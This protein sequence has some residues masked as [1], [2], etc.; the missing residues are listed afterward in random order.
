MGNDASLTHVHA[1]AFVALG[2]VDFSV[3]SVRLFYCHGTMGRCPFRREGISLETSTDVVQKA[4]AP[5]HRQELACQRVTGKK[6]KAAYD[7]FQVC[8]R[9]RSLLVSLDTFRFPPLSA[10]PI[11]VARVDSFEATDSEIQAL[12]GFMRASRREVFGRSRL[13]SAAACSF[14]GLRISITR[15]PVIS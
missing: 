2:R 6:A 15:A 14:A 13:P 4:A 5:P 1:A 7:R 9:Y 10:A 12:L 8:Q 3:F 11:L